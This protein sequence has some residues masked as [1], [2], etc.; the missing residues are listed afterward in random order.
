MFDA[1]STSTVATDVFVR[2]NDEFRPLT[3]GELS[4]KYDAFLT[5]QLAKAECSNWESASALI[6][7]ALKAR[8]G[9]SEREVFGLVMLNNKFRV[10]EIV[11]M[12]L[13]SVSGVDVKPGMRQSRFESE[14]CQRDCVS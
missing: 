4:E 2:I 12:H 9:L 11:V 3:L 10:L 5:N 14:R 6:G 7:T 13:G 8:Y 1:P